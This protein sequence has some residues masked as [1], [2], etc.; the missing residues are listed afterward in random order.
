ML[1]RTKKPNP[2]DW[3]HFFQWQSFL[4]VDIFVWRLCLCNLMKWSI[5]QDG[6]AQMH[7]S[8]A[9]KIKEVCVCASQFPQFPSLRP[10]LLPGSLVSRVLKTKGTCKLT[11]RIAACPAPG[12]FLFTLCLED[13]A[14]LLA[15]SCVVIAA[16][17]F[18]KSWFLFGWNIIC[19]SNAVFSQYYNAPPPHPHFYGG[20]RRQV[21][22]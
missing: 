3:K 6:G 20:P 1:L 22:T 14:L 7:K 5:G 15:V 19:I 21:H 12:F 11:P 2:E 13:P 10:P 16:L 9:V 17:V 18:P 8:F 4:W